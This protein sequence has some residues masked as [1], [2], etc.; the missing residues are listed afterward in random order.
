ML[1]LVA[2]A[3][4]HP[5]PTVAG[6]R[7][8]ALYLDSGGRPLF[9]WLHRPEGG[10]GDHAVLICPPIGHEQ[11]HSHRGLRHLADTL[12]RG[13]FPTLRLDYFATGD[14]AGLD[15]DAGVIAA[16]VRSVADARAWLRRE[17]GCA[18]VTLVGLRVGALFATL[19]AAEEPADGLVLWAPVVKGRSFVRE[20]KALSLMA[21][22]PGTGDLEAA[23]LVLTAA[24]AGDLSGLDATKTAPRCRRALI[25]DRDDAP[26]EAGLAQH[27]RALG[28]EVEQAAVPGYADLMAEPH[29][30]KVPDEAIARAAAWVVQGASSV[31][32]PTS[33]DTPGLRKATAP[34]TQTTVMDEGSWPC[35]AV[36]PDTGVRERALTLGPGGELFGVLSEPTDPPTG[37]PVVVLL[38][39]GSACHVGPNRLH[40]LLARD[41]AA[42]GFRVLRLDLRGLGDSPAA[43]P[44]RE[45]HPYP[46]TT[47]RDIDLALTHLHDRLGGERAVL[48][49]LCSGAY[50][51]F[52]SAARLAHPLLVES[53][54]VNPL[55]FHWKDGMS[56]DV[57]PAGKLEMSRAVRAALLRPSKWLK[58]LAGR[59]RLGIAGA[60]RA[61]LG[62]WRLGGAKGE[63]ADLLNGHPQEED[64][65]ADLRRAAAAGRH[66]TFVFARSDPG[67]ALLEASAGRELGRLCRSGR[68]TVR[69]IEDADHTFSRRAARAVF[70]ATVGDH[71]C[72][73]YRPEQSDRVG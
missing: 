49:G 55:T 67:H 44:A 23:G 11:V 68:V 46:D 18:K 48:V 41:L 54:V 1:S 32:G 50:A 26:A 15:E 7:R 25:L 35:E 10:H 60:V 39:A 33:G 8:T 43:D 9:A 24:A 73:R 45:N 57:S 27:L 3:D 37:L 5:R 40:V 51:A 31:S 36:L 71:L 12:A 21:G 66:L 20:M 2:S 69:Y 61:L 52:Q 16:R 6:V 58:L 47:F 28:V 4:R 38:N 30:T 72:D 64:V 53:I 14:S 13:G 63:G 70:V 19:S 62:G 29:H 42:R 17:V 34:A 22:G 59:T 65:P 56:L